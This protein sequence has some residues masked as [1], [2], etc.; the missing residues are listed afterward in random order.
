M[1]IGIVAGAI[2]LSSIIASL[3]NETL[4]QVHASE[5]NTQKLEQRLQQNQEIIPPETIGTVQ[6]QGETI[7]Y[8]ILSDT[9]NHST[10]ENLIY[11]RTSDKI[12]PAE[13]ISREA[14]SPAT[15]YQETQTLRPET[16]QQNTP[17]QN[18][19]TPIRRTTSNLSG[20]E[21][22]QRYNRNNA[23]T[24]TSNMQNNN[25]LWAVG[26]LLG[27]SF[28][29]GLE[30]KGRLWFD[31]DEENI[32]NN[33]DTPNIPVNGS[34][35]DMPFIGLN[36]TR[37]INDNWD[38]GIL[39]LYSKTDGSWTGP[40][41]ASQ[42]ITNTGFDDEGFTTYDVDLTSLAIGAGTTYNIPLK[43]NLTLGINLFLDYIKMNADLDIHSEVREFEGGLR[44]ESIGS[45]SF[46]Y[47]GQA[48]RLI[49]GIEITYT[50]GKDNQHEFMIGARYAFP[51][52][53]KQDN[54]VRFETDVNQSISGRVFGQNINV[55]NQQKGD[56]IAQ[57]IKANLESLD[58]FISYRYNF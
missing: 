35:T 8:R 58:L 3:F 25:N 31:S 18:P 21:F 49:P 5:N 45:T 7:T 55:N 6:H 43:D 1:K 13:L 9:E 50:Q 47:D 28:G 11:L 40:V 32:V 20:Q 15:T 57:G 14:I 48:V 34:V 42:N 12:I 33:D 39:G 54:D 46:D 29:Q 17:S 4:G 41:E 56:G 36:L 27:Y 2:T 30:F 37:R 22:Q 26:P 51:L 16:P 52:W 53:D 24:T 19:L 38:I 44:L 23:P 10:I